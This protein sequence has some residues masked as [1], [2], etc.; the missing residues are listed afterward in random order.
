MS[1]PKSS[2]ELMARGRLAL[3]MT[4][5]DLAQ[6]LGCSRRTMHRWM[7]GETSIG[8]SALAHLA[9][10]VLPRDRALAEEIAAATSATQVRLGLA[11]LPPLDPPDSP[12]AMPLPEPAPPLPE[13]A[14]APRP[15][16]ITHAVVCAAAEA[17]DLS[18]RA[19]RPAIVAAFQCARALGLS[20][21]EV[22]EGLSAVSSEE[23]A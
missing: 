14:P 16:E 1:R 19:L 9:R 13:P 7:A 8:V 18:P 22:Q 10:L 11:P 5:V 4:S 6:T 12:P 15:P 2:A 21:A 23:T 3:G 17:M 20:V